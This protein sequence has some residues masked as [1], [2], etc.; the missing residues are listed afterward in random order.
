MLIKRNFLVKLGLSGLFALATQSQ[1]L[2]VQLS[3]TLTEFIHTFDG[4]I[5]P[6]D[7][8]LN[9]Q[10]FNTGPITF[11]LDKSENPSEQI[12]FY[13]F[14]QMIHKYS[15]DVL[16]DAPLLDNLGEPAQKIRINLEGPITNINPSDLTP[17]VFTDIQI[18]SS[19]LTGGGVFSSGQLLE[20]WKY[21]NIQI[22]VKNNTVNTNGN[23]NVIDTKPSNEQNV[24]GEV[25]ATLE[26]PQCEEPMEEISPQQIC[27]RYSL[28]GFGTATVNPTPRSVPEPA[29]TLGLLSVGILG[30]NLS[31][32]RKNKH[33]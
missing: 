31:L 16:V 4:T 1:S 20:G 7:I 15:V 3:G 25:D 12:W 2:A 28:I 23:G 29:S 14:D 22:N 11:T 6:I 27:Q 33:N 32:K 9:E 24:E 30:L 8:V 21:S 13:D 19:T 17:G 18:S 5:S 26:S 10:T